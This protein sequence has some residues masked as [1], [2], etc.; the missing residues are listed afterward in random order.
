MWLTGGVSVVDRKPRLLFL[1]THNAARS[2]IAE[3][4]LRDL[5]KGTVEVYSAGTEPTDVHPLAIRALQEVGTDISAQ[6]S[7]YVDEFAGQ[8]FDF[9]VTLCDNA[10]EVCPVFP[11]APERIHWSFSDPGAV[12]GTEEERLQSFSQ[13]ARELAMRLRPF[14]SLVERPHSNIGVIVPC[15]SQDS[16]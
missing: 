2:Q 11:G 8:T 10:R 9:V 3:G 4:I 14:L 16:A 15:A 12:Q 5:S 13:T 7:K 6:R 1:C